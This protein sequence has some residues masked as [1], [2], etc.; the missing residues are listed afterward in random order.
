[1][2]IQFKVRPANNIF[3]LFALP[4]KANYEAAKENI[5]SLKAEKFEPPVNREKT[6]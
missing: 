4:T 3:K 5:K 6:L 1:M 2:K